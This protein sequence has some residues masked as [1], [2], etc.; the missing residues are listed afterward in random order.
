M[1]ELKDVLRR[2]DDVTPDD[3]VFRRAHGG[4]RR[5]LPPRRGGGGERV[6]A[7]LTALAVSL[8][9]GTFAWR[10]FTSPVEQEDPTPVDVV[11]LG[12]DGSTLWPQR[13]RAELIS[14][15]TRTDA[16]NPGYRWQL[17]RDEVVNRFGE[18]VLG[19]PTDT[20]RV[21]MEEGPVTGSM[22]AHLIRTEET[23]P[24]F[25]PEDEARGVARCFPGAEDVTVAQ[26]IEEGS[27]G[28]WVVVSV[29]APTLPVGIQPGQVVGNGSSVRAHVDVD[30]GLF[31]SWTVTIG[32]AGDD[33]NCF[34]SEDARAADGDLEIPVAIEPD[35]TAGTDC[36]PDAAGYV[37]VET[38]TFPAP[39]DPLNAD[40]TGF[41]GV[42]AVPISVSIPENRPAAGMN[43]YTDP[44]GW[45]VDLPEPWSVA[46][47]DDVAGE[48]T[49]TISNDALPAEADTPEGPDP[50][51]FPP[52][53]VVL[54]VTHLVGE[55]SPETAGHDTTFP[56][57]P[58]LLRSL[59]QTSESPALEFQGNGLAYRVRL[60]VGEEAT[61]GDV[62]AM[63]DV[64]RSL[65]FPP[66]PGG[67]IANGWRSLGKIREYA[68]GRGTAT[69][70]KRWGVIYVVRGTGGTYVI[71]LVP[72]TCGEGQN[73][74]WDGDRSQI[75][76]ECPDG[77]EIRYE[78]DG[79]PVAG[80]PPAYAEPLDV[81]PAITAWD[82]T[83]LVSVTTTIDDVERYWPHA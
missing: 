15:Q 45:K 69:F 66:L 18:S 38:T 58:E 26:P 73:Q 11:P 20:F 13:T 51:T 4:P 80:N 83:V 31:A 22:V 65:R 19:W 53:L 37:V 44:L 32:D 24:P 47:V 50:A 60:F 6:I 8:L 55:P 79:R 46:P 2:F 36:G 34:S 28:I 68:K 59:F 82:G 25:T 67:T 5:P 57:D 23:C 21:T 16:G 39:A 30:E 74:T 78:R 49:L 14:A 17:D 76:V 52:D 77:S 63:L 54:E 40:W 70:E 29:R 9:A 64:V 41:V 56:L 72:E 1:S 62:A 12:A 42:T 35:A 71:D 48:R 7:G 61:D 3:E 33:R 27:E 43:V 75:L 10:A 81:Y